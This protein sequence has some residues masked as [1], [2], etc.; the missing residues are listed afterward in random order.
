M[1][2]VYTEAVGN[3]IVCGEDAAGSAY[4]IAMTQ[5]QWLGIRPFIE[6][7]IPVSPWSGVKLVGN[8]YFVAEYCK[9]FCG[10]QCVQVHYKRVAAD[11]LKKGN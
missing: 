1:L 9:P 11:N 2:E 4:W 6:D 3:C 8:T 7:I 10:P 5:D